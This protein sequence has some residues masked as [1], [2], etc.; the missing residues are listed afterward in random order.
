[1]VSLVFITDAVFE[2]NSFAGDRISSGPVC[3]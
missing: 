2:V 1:M 3:R